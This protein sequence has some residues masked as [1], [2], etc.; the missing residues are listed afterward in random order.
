VEWV[1]RQ[2]LDKDYAGEALATLRKMGALRKAG[3]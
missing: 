3:K 2:K 1:R